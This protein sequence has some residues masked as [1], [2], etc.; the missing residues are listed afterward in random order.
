MAVK[1][2]SKVTA[3]INGAIAFTAAAATTAADGFEVEFD[4][5][6]NQTV[7]IATNAHAT[8]AKTITV[9]AGTGFQAGQDWT[10]SIAAGAFYAIRLD[11][12]SHKQG[13]VVKIIPA[14]TDIK[15][16]VVELA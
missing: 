16:A 10:Q 3:P 2:I 4:G 7:I 9:K 15:V 6:D 14:S 11:S 5:K 13:D 12:G 8:D 1:E